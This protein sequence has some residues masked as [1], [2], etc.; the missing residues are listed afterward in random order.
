[1]RCVAFISVR[2]G[3]D[4]IEKCLSHLICNGVEVVIIDQSST[5]GTYEACQK[6]LGNGVSKIERV[7]YPGYF[8]LE[9]Q[10]NQKYKLIDETKTDWVIHQD[11]DELLVSPYAN[12]SLIESIKLEDSKSYNVINFNEFVFL[13]YDDTNFY[14]SEYYYFFE[15]SS[16]R[17]MRSWKKSANL[18]TFDGHLL[19]GDIKL[20]PINYNLRHYIFI[21]QEHAFDKY[22]K[23]VFSKNETDRG[24]HIN[25]INIHLNKLVFPEKELLNK[26]SDNQYVELS[27]DNPW[28]KHY[29]DML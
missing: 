15:P 21:S 8:S 22:S 5:D 1:M 10:L 18:S 3:I 23:R 29:W 7:L 24:Q 9:E 20:S 17:L 25:R 26:C 11:V 19:K 27:I 28:K 14:D 6:F 12:L 4:Y 2:D 16:P 13:P